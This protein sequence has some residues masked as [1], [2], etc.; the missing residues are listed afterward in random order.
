MSSQSTKLSCSSSDDN[1]IWL[2]SPPPQDSYPLVSDIYSFVPLPFTE[3]VDTH[4]SSNHPVNSLNLVR[5]LHGVA[6]SFPTN[7]VRFT[8]PGNTRNDAFKFVT[9]M[10][11]TIQWNR[12][13]KTHNASVPVKTSLSGKRLGRPPI[14]RFKLEYTCP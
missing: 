5:R 12:E 7:P 3:T 9:A 10:Q 2:P 8:I 13:R 1:I 11:A 14:M 4:Q 6:P